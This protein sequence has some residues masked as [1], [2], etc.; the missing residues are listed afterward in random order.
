VPKIRGVKPDYWT[1][2]DIVDLSIP[3][4]LLFIGLWTYAC[5]NGHLQDKPKQIK[6]RVFPATTSTRPSC[7]ANWRPR[8][9]H[10]G[11]RWIT[12]PNL[13]EHQKPDLR[14]FTTC[15]KEGCDDPPEKVSQRKSRR[16]HAVHTVSTQGVPDVGTAS[17]H[18]DGDGEGEGEV[19]VSVKPASK[20]RAPHHF[21]DDFEPNQNNRE[22]AARQ[23][24]D[25]DSLIE[26]FADHHR[27]KGSKFKD[28]NLALN[29]W[30]RR[31]RPG[32]AGVAP[33][34]TPFPR[35]GTREEQD[36]WVAAQPPVAWVG[37]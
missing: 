20:S 3:A 28:W 9:H 13:T 25:L 24:V 36:A 35:N 34:R 2:E 12:I 31:E 7:C 29:T 11:R 1:D 17:A 8:A 32:A 26:Q 15:D 10:K 18:V 30:I 37:G 19:M 23:G 22:V 5:D 27:A 16:V 6:M 21:P 4:R 14:Y 33:E